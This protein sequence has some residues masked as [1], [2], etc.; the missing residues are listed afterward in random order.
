MYYP[1]LSPHIRHI[2]T[3]HPG[4][5]AVGWLDGRHEF[6]TGKVGFR[7]AWK[8]RRLVKHPVFLT[9]GHHICELC[10]APTGRF[11][12]PSEEVMGNGE[13]WLST[14]DGVIYAFPTLLSHYIRRHHYL[15]PPPFVNAVKPGKQLSE[16]QCMERIEAHQ[17]QLETDPKPE[18]ILVPHYAVRLMWH[19]DDFDNLTSFQTELSQVEEVCR[20]GLRD[21]GYYYAEESHEP[22]ELFHRICEGCLEMDIPTPYG[23]RYC[24]PLL[25]EDEEVVIP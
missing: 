9:R 5:L 8:I 11:E 12:S 16:S 21:F 23:Y 7:D 13:V 14:P 6:P 15:P 10:S 25:S 20:V 2:V 24:Q 1:D 18:D 22:S 4:V 19:K 3:G 17:S